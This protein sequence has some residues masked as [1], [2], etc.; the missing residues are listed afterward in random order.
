MSKRY[1]LLLFSL[2]VIFIAFFTMLCL[3]S[4]L[5]TDDYFF[6]WDVRHHG[7]WEGVR[8][9]YMEWCGRYAATGL[10]DVIYKTLDVDQT[11]YFLFPLCSFLLLIAA[12]YFLFAA[13]EFQLHFKLERIQRF[14]F[15]TLF[16]IL[17]FFLSVDIGETWIWYCSL[18]SYLWSIIAF[19]WGCAFLA[20]N[21]NK[22]VSVL[23]SSICFIYAGGSSEVYSVIYGVL[24][25]AFM[26]TRYKKADSLKGFIGN[27]LNRKIIFVYIVFG[28]AFLVFLIAPGNYLRDELFP[29]HEL[30][31]T[32]FITA[33]SIVK[34]GILYL[35]PRLAYIL[36]F[37]APF[38]ILGKHISRSHTKRFQ[39][40]FSTFFIKASVLFTGLTLLF[41]LIVA[42]VMVETGPPR[43]WFILSFL[44]ALYS[45]S[46]CFY[47][48]Y[49]GY[50]NDNKIKILSVASLLL[51]II[52]IGYNSIHQFFIAGNYSRAHN[53]R[54]EQLLEL[55]QQIHTDTLI[56]L[57]A[58]P[59]SGMLYSSEIA[60]DTNHF[61]NKE[62]RLGYELKFHVISPGK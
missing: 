29:K 57:P 42:Y 61:T 2:C 37:A 33:K 11:Y 45:V 25:L 53:R 43:I 27:E 34:F 30:L 40:S 6:I 58:L 48:G 16:S 8:S 15:S 24:I 59:S 38:I 56:V 26:L 49:S 13:L 46:T 55:K 20:G 36:A 23:M 10:M 52:I 35:P 3:Y 47:A 32:F 28:I 12:I 4:R 22:I 9:Q 50:L 19:I 7:V 31:N 14:V 21:Y 1:T 5:A 62:L 51:A 44:F 41:F 54:I 60:A 18:S 39:L 17:L